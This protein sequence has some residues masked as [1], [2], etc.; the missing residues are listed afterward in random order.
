MKDRSWIFI[1]P[2]RKSVVMHVRRDVG[3][4]INRLWSDI[5]LNITIVAR[6]AINGDTRQPIRELPGIIFDKYHE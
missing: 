2:V 1:P 3:I 5:K 6:Q 4:I